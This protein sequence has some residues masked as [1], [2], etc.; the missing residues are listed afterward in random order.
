MPTSKQ[1]GAI[2]ILTAVLGLGGGALG[3]S[4]IDVPAPESV[5][6]ETAGVPNIVVDDPHDLLAPEDEAR[7]MRDA[8]MLE[9]PDTVE[10]LHWM[11][12]N[13]SHENLNDTVEEYMRDHYPDDIGPDK[14]ADGV[15][16]VAAG[17]QQRKVGVYAGEDVAHQLK[18]HEDERAPSVAEEMKRGM[19]DSNIPAAM[20]AGARAAMDI[21]LVRAYVVDDAE[22]E[23]FGAGVGA[24]V[25]AGGAAALGSSLALGA[26]NRRRQAITR[27][28]RDHELVTRE[29][30]ALGQRLGEIDIRANSLTSAFA[31]AEMRKQWAEVRDRFLALHDKVS[32]AGGIGA[33]DVGDDKQV[34]ERRLEID[35]AAEVVRHTSNAEDNINRLFKIENGDPAA[36]RSDLTALR[37]DIIKARLGVND[38]GLKDELEELEAKINELDHNP[39]APGFLDDFVRLLGDYRLVLEAVKDKE[40]SDVKE[41]NALTRPALYDRDFF[42]S[43][44][45]P[46]VVL[47]SW[48]TSNVEAAQAAQSSSSSGFNSSY[49]SGFSGAGGSS[50]Y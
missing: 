1:I 26:R 28:R 37:E 30:A 24:G 15:L 16:I 41:H 17:T 47:N 49:S 36:R 18:L 35:N 20:F 10:V 5:A 9:A 27:A 7:M 33:I 14:Y 34:W 2:A 13:Q 11:V 50:S 4:F 25:A 40:F 32:G 19:R 23:R 8:A 6:I 42:Y 12:F 48:H 3:A 31:D 44:Y 21:D 29:Y 45:V 38:D 22:S 46:F 39:S 43:N